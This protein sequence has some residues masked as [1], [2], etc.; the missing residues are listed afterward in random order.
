MKSNFKKYPLVS[1]VTPSFNDAE[2]IMDNI[3]S[4]QNQKWKNIEHIIFDGK[5]TD[6]TTNILKEA[7]GTEK[8][9]NG[10]DCARKLIHAFP[11]LL[12]LKSGSY[13]DIRTFQYKK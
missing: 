6:G 11:E 13:A 3:K 8:M 5:S 2:F 1:I 7:K 10:E 9:P 12:I 4:V